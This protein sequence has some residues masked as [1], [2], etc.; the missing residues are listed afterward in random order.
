MEFLEQNDLPHIYCDMDEVLVD[1]VRGADLAVGGSFIKYDREERWRKI[2][3][4][5]DFWENLG[6]KLDAEI[7][8]DFIIPYNSYILS[9]Y[10][11]RDPSSRAGKIKWV[12]KNTKFKISNIHLVLRAQKKNY[13]KT[14]AGMQNI[15]IDD[16][17]KNIREWEDEGG[18]GILHSEV[19]KTIKDLKC[20]GFK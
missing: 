17:D 15:L 6:W 3:K 12:E 5:G 11:R 20:L 4:I 19:G 2:N 1:F 16:Y 10:T 14:K 13:A 9:A 8:H 18:I 7:L